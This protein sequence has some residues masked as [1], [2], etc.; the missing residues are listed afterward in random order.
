MGL[1][2][3]Y[4][5]KGTYQ[6]YQINSPIHDVEIMLSKTFFN[7]SLKATFIA[8]DVLKTFKTNAIAQANN[9]K[10][11]YSLLNDTQSFRVGISYNFGKFSTNHKQQETEQPDELKRI[12][13][14]G[15]IGPKKE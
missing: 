2:Y 10:V 3:S 4:V 13:K 9:I 5:T 7:Q 6:V 14:R 12:D 1:N 11:D 8:K 15:E